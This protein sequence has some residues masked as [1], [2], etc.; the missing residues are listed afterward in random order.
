MVSRE[1]DPRAL[2]EQV[3]VVHRADR[4]V[5][6]N[7]PAGLLSVPGKGEANKTCAADWVRVHSPHARGPIIVHRL[8][9]DTSGLLVLALD[10]DTQRDL[11]RQFESR[12]VEKAYT[13]VVEG[14]VRAECGEISVPVRTDFANR[15]YQ[16]VDHTHDKPAVTAWRVMAYEPD[17]TRLELTPHTGRTHQLRVHCAYSGPG[18]LGGGG[19]PIVGDVLYGRAGAETEPRLLLH[20]SFLSITDPATGGRIDVRCAPDF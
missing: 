5:V 19:H 1:R 20:A 9:M 17:R 18:G 2:L 3:T 15:P 4:F 13:A 11:S 8:D 14:H 10:E 7:K 6:I 16:I 12:T